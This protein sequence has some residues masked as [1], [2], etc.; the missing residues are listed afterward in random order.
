MASVDAAAPKD[1]LSN[2]FSILS[3][4][5]SVNML[6][7]IFEHRQPRIGDFGTRKRYYE[8]MARLKKAHLIT[9]KENIGYELTVLGSSLYESFLTLQRAKNLLW[10]LKAIDDL[11]EVPNEELK[12]LIETLIPDE[13]IRKILLE[14][15]DIDDDINN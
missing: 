8:R 10:N 5:D 2:I 6:E 12:K 14:K 1:L 9:K 11:D 4:E 13:A 7:M 3:D 15:Y